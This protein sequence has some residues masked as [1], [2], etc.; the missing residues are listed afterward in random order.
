MI[1]KSLLGTPAA[2]AAAADILSRSAK[3]RSHDAL[4]EPQGYALAYN[5][6]EIEESC[7]KFVD[8]QLPELLAKS[9]DVSTMERRLIEIGEEFRHIIYHIT[10][11]SFYAYL[12]NEPDEQGS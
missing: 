8:V 11:P 2:I 12:K 3:V 4:D 9:G 1:G 7:K 6:S 5:F 10:A